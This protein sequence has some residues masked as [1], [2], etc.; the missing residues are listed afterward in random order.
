MS[1]WYALSYVYRRSRSRRCGNSAMW[2][3]VGWLVIGPTANLVIVSLFVW[4]VVLG[5]GMRMG[6]DLPIMVFCR[7][8]FLVVS[9]CIHC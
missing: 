9:L 7:F 8:T 6:F 1:K 4:V 5:F 3:W 2:G